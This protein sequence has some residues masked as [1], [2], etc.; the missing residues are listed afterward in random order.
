MRVKQLSIILLMA[1]GG[2][3]LSTAVAQGLDSLRIDLNTALEIALSENPKVKVAD[4]EITKKVYAKKSAY[5]A[6]L[7]QFDLIGQYQRA[8][9]RQTVYFDGGLGLGGSIDPTKFTEDELKIVETVG[10]MFASDPESADEGFQ[11]GRLNVY[12]AGL[13]VSMPLVVP[14]LWKNI[15]MSQVDIE[16]PWRSPFAH[17][18]GEPGEEVVLLPVAGTGQLRGVQED[19]CHR[20]C[21]TWKISAT[22]SNRAL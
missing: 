1:C 5:G 19:I 17:R 9:Q 11:M 4:M 13:N 7:P 20:F 22:G 3:R 21:S 16:L 15:Q 12:T 8:I 6:L 2:L 14:S 18:P 10:K